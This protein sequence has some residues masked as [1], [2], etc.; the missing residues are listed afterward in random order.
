[1]ATYKVILFDLDGT[2]SDP[3]EGITRSVQSALQKMN[4]VVPDVDSLEGFIG[5]PLQLSF[6]DYFNLDEIQIKNAIEFYRERFKGKGMYENELYSNIP[7]LLHSLKEK[8]FILV[9]ATSKP[10]VFS[11][12]ILQHFE[13]DHYF[14]LVVGS[15]LDGTRTSKTEIIQ[16]I[17]DAYKPYKLEDFIMIGDRKH[18]I[19]GANKNGIDSIGVT[20]GYGSYEELSNSKP[21]YIVGTVERVKDILMGSQVK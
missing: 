3:K 1:M 18:D 9:V 17:L 15:N 12:Q 21:T 2:I 5:P 14:D 11:E 8:G 20:Y 13:I 4:I 19:E 16:Y 10:T 6:S 7:L